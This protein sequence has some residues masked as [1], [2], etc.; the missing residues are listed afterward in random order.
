MQILPSNWYQD[1]PK[2]I[3]E[4]TKQCTQESLLKKP[5]WSQQ[6]GTETKKHK[7]SKIRFKKQVCSTGGRGGG[8]N[9]S[10]QTGFSERPNKNHRYF[11]SHNEEIGCN[12]RKARCS[13]NKIN[14]VTP[15]ATKFQASLRD[16]K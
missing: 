15:N 1:H 12:G 2:K 4:N 11:S 3:W 7:H 8:G 6:K 14:T 9:N 10:C 13:I 5:V 16:L